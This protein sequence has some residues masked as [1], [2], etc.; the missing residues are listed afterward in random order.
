MNS[1]KNVIFFFIKNWLFVSLVIHRYIVHNVEKNTNRSSYSFWDD[2]NVTVLI[3]QF[4]LNRN[5]LLVFFL[6]LYIFTF[7]H[8]SKDGRW[9]KGNVHLTIGYTR[10]INRKF[11][12]RSQ[13][14][15]KILNLIDNLI[16]MLFQCFL[17]WPTELYLIEFLFINEITWLVKPLRKHVVVVVAI[18]LKYWHLITLVMIFFSFFFYFR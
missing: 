15:T 3:Y 5:Y 16:K 6:L 11:G 18:P 1:F 13:Y 12:K 4:I 2:F 8:I 14:T 7:N 9:H 17:C 10:I